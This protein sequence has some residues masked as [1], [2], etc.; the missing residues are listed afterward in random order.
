MAMTLEKLKGDPDFR[1]MFTKFLANVDAYRLNEAILEEIYSPKK[2]AGTA[3][4][5][6]KQAAI[7]MWRLE[8]SLEIWQILITLLDERPAEVEEEY[9]G[10]L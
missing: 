8:G 4:E 2:R 10:E 6:N 9:N 3:D 5:L 1:E 7:D